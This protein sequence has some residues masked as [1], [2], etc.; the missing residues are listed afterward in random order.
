M[1]YYIIFNY[2]N[3]Y[4]LLGMLFITCQFSVSTSNTI[5]WF[6][7]CNDCFNIRNYYYIMIVNDWIKIYLYFLSIVFLI[8]TLIQIEISMYSYEYE[9]NEYLTFQVLCIHLKR[10]RHEFMY[11]SKIGSYVSF[12]LEGLDMTPYLHKDCTDEV[13]MYDLVSVICHHGTAGG[14]LN[15]ITDGGVMVCHYIL[16]VWI[17]LSCWSFYFLCRGRFYSFYFFCFLIFRLH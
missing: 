15:Q 4:L 16:S 11:S 7:L 10:F 9:C 17:L 13:P 1:I 5:N 8:F 2:I 3:G 6:V 14:R 12:P